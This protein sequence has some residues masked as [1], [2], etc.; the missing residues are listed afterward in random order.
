MVSFW[1]QNHDQSSAFKFG[2]LL[3]QCSFLGSLGNF[4]EQSHAE[5]GQSDFTPPEYDGYFYLVFSVNKLLYMT[6][7]GL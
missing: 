4:F 3:Y 2:V 1:R 7:L 5:P 6:D